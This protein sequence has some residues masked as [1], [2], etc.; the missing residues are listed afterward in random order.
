LTVLK[1]IIDAASIIDKQQSINI[2]ALFDNEEVGS[3]SF[4]GADSNFFAE[5][6]KRIFTTIETDEK[7]E[8]DSFEA[9]CARSFCISADMAHA[10][11]PNYGEKY[12]PQHKPEMHKG[13]TIKVNPNTRYATDS[14]GS[15]I[16]KELCNNRSLLCQE[17]IVKQDSP[18]GTTIGPIISGKLGIKTVD[19]GMPQWAMHSI[20]ETCGTIDLYYYRSLFEEFFTGYENVVGNLIKK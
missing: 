1:S 15:A 9:H 19:I 20:R 16:I 7:P 8:N 5:N 10:W 17:F 3:L 12:Q 14:E 11:N 18:C 6:L 2:I 4:Q 13:V